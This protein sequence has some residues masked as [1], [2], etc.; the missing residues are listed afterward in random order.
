MAWLQRLVATLWIAILGIT[1]AWL[2]TLAWVHVGP[3]SPYGRQWESAF[4]LSARVFRV[5]I[6]GPFGLHAL[7]G[8]GRPSA[9]GDPAT[10]AGGRPRAPRRA[11]LSNPHGHR[12]PART[13]VR[14]PRGSLRL[15]LGHLRP[16]GHRRL[17]ELHRCRPHLSAGEGLVQSAAGFNQPTFW[18]QDFSPNFPD[19]TRAGHNP[20]YSS[21][22]AAVAAV[23][24]LEH[25]DAAFV[26]GPAAYAAL[27]HPPSCSLLA[28]W[29]LPPAYWRRRSSPTR[30][31]GCS[32][33][34]GPSLW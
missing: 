33:A 8:G 14:G 19:K 17:D 26:I 24:G 25:A 10:S 30:S 9:D 16:P 12:R 7:Q 27:W 3:Y 15:A 1:L 31:A 29:D 6:A 21:L 13:A 22:I 23:T 20:G 32:C 11:A 34:R 28:S 18:A 4:H 2:A 5:A